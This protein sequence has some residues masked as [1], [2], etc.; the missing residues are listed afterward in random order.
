MWHDRDI[1]AGTA[2]E[3][4]IGKQMDD[5]QIILLLVSPDFMASDYCYNNEMVHALKKHEE[6]K[7]HV[8][9][10]IV[11]PVD[12][13]GA[14][15]AHLQ[16]LPR[17][18]EPVT[19]WVK[20]DDAF[21]DIVKGIRTVLKNQFSLA[22]STH[23][24]AIPIKGKKIKSRTVV[25]A[26]VFVVVILIISGSSIYL[27]MSSNA[28]NLTTKTSMFTPAN[29][30]TPVFADPLLG[31]NHHDGWL[32][33]QDCVFANDGFHVS[34]PT[35]NY[36][37]F[38]NADSTN[39]HNFVYEVQMKIVKGMWGGLIYRLDANK[40]NLYSFGFNWDGTYD[41]DIITAHSVNVLT[42]GHSPAFHTGLDQLNTLRIEAKENI[43]KFYVNNVYVTT[44][45]DN[46]FT[47]GQIGVA[48]YAADTPPVE[49][50]FTNAKVWTL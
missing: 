14:P 34:T 9:P 21:L 29:N 25:V 16:F 36:I 7:T 5:A 49:V 17:N 4:E 28:G 33:G 6:G 22:E 11:R 27:M 20:S 37:D 3:Q 30:A 26:A 40:T 10:I 15:F 39:F 12:L 45:T 13:Q 47:N 44:T 35:K 32:Q 43:V 31:N 48:V 1:S 18:A 50:I 42:E 41:V 24:P 19:N 23:L 2:W 38:C 8:I 46:N